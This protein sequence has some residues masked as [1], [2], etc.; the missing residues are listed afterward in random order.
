MS[1]ALQIMAD[2]T[3]TAGILLN[4]PGKRHGLTV[5][6]PKTIE[7]SAPPLIQ[8]AG[9]HV[10]PTDIIGYGYH[11]QTMFDYAKVDTVIQRIIRQSDPKIIIFGSVARHEA[12][13]YSD[14][15]L[16]VVFDGPV[17][18]KAMYYELSGLFIGLR[19][20]FDLVIMNYDDFI[21]YKDLDQSFTHEITTTGTI[22]YS[23][24]RSNH[25]IAHNDRSLRNDSTIAEN[26]IGDRRALA[27][28]TPFSEDRIG[29]N[30]AL[31]PASGHD[32]RVDDGR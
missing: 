26:L 25:A 23:R 28:R 27:H 16:L 6:R 14:L 8:I 30:G 13:D 32:Q 12:R 9:L 2:D 17:N 31:D 7:D 22:V 11:P 21:H 29:Q 4:L 19:L 5:L 24:R 18:Q 10:E 1:I 3:F 15:D 20:P